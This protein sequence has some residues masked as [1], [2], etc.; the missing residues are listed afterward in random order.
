[1]AHIMIVEDDLNTNKL[2]TYL[3]EHNGYQVY[4]VHNVSEALKLMDHQYVDLILLDVMLPGTDG[5]EFIKELRH[6]GNN[7]PIIILTAKQLHEDICNGFLSGADDYMTKPFQE[8]ELLLRIKAL[9]RRMKITTENKLTIGK[10][11]LYYDSLLVTRENERHTLPQKEFYLLYKLLSYPDKIFTRLQLM[12]EIW[13]M[14]STSSE[15]TVNVHINR[16]RN[17]FRD[18]PEFDLVAVRGLG[19]KAVKNV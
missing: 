16:L 11:T 19:Y 14:D 4:S 18:Y 6:V 10:V 8:E 7:I 12:D 2:L 17:R 3:L 13:G 15:V 9:L 1:M 5:F